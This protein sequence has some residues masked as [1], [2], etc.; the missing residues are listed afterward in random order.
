MMKKLFALVLCL[1][2]VGGCA[3]AEEIDLSGMPYDDLVALKDRINLAIWESDE[4]QEVEVPHG[5]WEI[6]K[7][8]PAGKWTIKAAE[9]VRARVDWGDKLDASG[10]DFEWGTIWIRQ[11]LES[12]TYAYYSGS[13]PTEVT[14][15]LKEGHYI[16]V[17]QGTVYFTPYAGKPSLGFK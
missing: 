6:G 11:F 10:W 17:Q 3:A 7:D 4:W 8:I 16:I 5:V 12:E 1:L 14:Y 9:G 2:M 15:D 13:Q